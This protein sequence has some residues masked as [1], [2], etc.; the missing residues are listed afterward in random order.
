MFHRFWKVFATFL[1]GLVVTVSAASGNG[2]AAPSGPV[3][4]VVSGAIKVTNQGETAEFD[5]AML[6]ALDSTVIETTTLWTDGVQRFRGA[7]LIALTKLLGIESGTLHAVAMND[8]STDIPVSDAVDGGPIIAY[9]LNGAHM[10]L[11]TKGPLWIVY[12]YDSDDAYRSEQ[13]YTRSIW[14]LDRIEAVQ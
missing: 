12:P 5:M 11:R 1:V 9:E 10:S 13:I 6:E 4:L 2:L 7:S 8:Y 14:Q 3:V